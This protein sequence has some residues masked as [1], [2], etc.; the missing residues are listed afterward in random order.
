M[1]IAAVATSLMQIIH[2]V[3]QV[4]LVCDVGPMEASAL[5]IEGKLHEQ[6]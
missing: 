2:V 3:K 1:R 5:K 6:L 4:V